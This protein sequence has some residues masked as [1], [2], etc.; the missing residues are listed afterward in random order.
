MIDTLLTCKTIT[1]ACEETKRRLGSE[2]DD[3]GEA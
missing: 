1:E 3:A 2:A